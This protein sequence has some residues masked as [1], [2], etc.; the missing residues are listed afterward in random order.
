MPITQSM[1]AQLLASNNQMA[2]EAFKT[3]GEMANAT[4]KNKGENKRASQQDALQRYLNSPSMK[5]QQAGAEQGAKNT[6]NLKTLQDPGLQDQLNQGGSA[7]VGD[8]RVGADPTAKLLGRVSTQAKTF[9]GIADKAYKPIN[10]QLVSSKA[11]L[12]ALDQHNSA[13]DKLAMINEARLAASSGGSRALGTIIPL[14]SGGKTSAG[15][16]QG[17]VN[18]LNNTP[19]VPTLQ[20]SQRNALREAVFSRVPQMAQMHQQAQQML[21]TQGPAIA[22]NAD[23]QS[24]TRSYAAPADQN[25]QQLQQ[26]QQGYQQSRVKSAAPGQPRAISQPSAGEAAPS[27]V[28]KLKGFLGGGQS[29]APQAASGAPLSKEEFLKQRAAQS[30]GQ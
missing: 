15:D 21:S 25:L 2:G 8:I 13:S 30:Q 14:L 20:D 19:D 1:L 7:Q 17:F 6:E 18:Y 10:D 26:M 28:D 27:M 22:P 11:T 24:I 29:Q 16:F 3:G 23:H 5:G 9:Q 12:D 4:E